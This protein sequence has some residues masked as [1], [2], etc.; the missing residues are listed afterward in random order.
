MPKNLFVTTFIVFLM[1]WA[2]LPATANQGSNK[3]ALEAAVPFSEQR[4]QI[5]RDLADGKTYA[6][7]TSDKRGQVIEALD[8]ITERLEAS[9]SIDAMNMRERIATFNDQELLNSILTQAEA[10]SA[11]VCSRGKKVGS[12]RT[13]TMCETVAE[14]HRRQEA[15]RDEIFKRA[16]RIVCNPSSTCAGG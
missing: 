11:V 15:A 14:R 3:V 1:L 9:G 4:A 13:I 6:E 7:I 12:H 2:P 16:N 10:D 8:R 5:L